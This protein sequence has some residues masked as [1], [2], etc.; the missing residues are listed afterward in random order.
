[1]IKSHIAFVALIIA[2]LMA[3]C[4]RKPAEKTVALHSSPLDM[5]AISDKLME[6]ISLQPGEK[7]FMIGVPGE[8]DSL[9]VFL[10]DKITSA[11][12]VYLGT[13]NVDTTSWPNSWNTDFVKSTK[14]KSKE[15]LI[16]LL[17]GYDLGIMLPGA[18]PSDAPYAAWQEVLNSGKGRSVHAHWAGANDL[19]GTSIPMD[20]E[21]NAFYQRVILDSDYAAIGATQTSFE[22]ALRKNGATITTPAGTNLSFKIGD[23]P[24]TKQ[25]GDVSKAHTDKGRNLIDREIEFPAGAI[26]VAPIEETVG[27]TIVFPQAVWGDQNVEGLVI[28]FKQGKITNIKATTGLDAVKAILAPGMEG[29]IFR[30]LGVGFNPLL[31]ITENNQR[32]L[33]YGYGSGIVRLSLGNNAELGGIVG[34][35]FGRITLFKDATLKTGSDVW[36][37]DGKLLE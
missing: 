31:A 27:G 33:H 9:I 22:E 5:D 19:N 24:V 15:E 8:F 3:S 14:G 1:M 21:I 28:T 17:D 36:I 7:V 25:D 26:R 13:I 16:K 20:A 10:G 37:K 35:D 23:R 2:L 4:D 6:K 29:Y 18:S 11:G 32:I 12:G 30:E 34:G